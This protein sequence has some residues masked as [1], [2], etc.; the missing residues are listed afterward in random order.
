MS[1]QNTKKSS[2]NEKLEKTSQS[3]NAQD[4][5]LVE[6]AKESVGRLEKK[7]RAQITRM[8]VIRRRLSF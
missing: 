2:K 1:A 3:G 4:T 8:E 6:A 7:N 5:N